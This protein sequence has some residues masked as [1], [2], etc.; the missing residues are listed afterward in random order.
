MRR[1]WDI[2]GKI[3][4][5]I[6]HADLPR[7]I[8]EL[9]EAGISVYAL[10]SI[11]ELTAR[12]TVSRDSW[13]LLR[14]IAEKR[15]AEV[16]ILRRQGLYWRL[17][18]ILRRP[19]LL[20]GIAVIVLLSGLLPSR[21]L[22]VE[23][24]GN[25]D[26]P[27]NQI[28]EAAETVGIC[29]GASRREIRSEQVK[30]RLLEL[31]PQ[32][33]WVGVNTSGCRA[34]ISVSE[35]AQEETAEADLNPSS[36]VA[37]RDGLIRSVTVTS[38]NALC[39]VGQAVKKGEVLVSAY[40]DCGIVIKAA[41]AR[42]EIFAETLRRIETVIP[43]FSE[44][45][46]EVTEVIKNYSLRIGKK[47]IKFYKDSG[48]Y[49]SSCDKMYKEYY[50][51]LPGGFTL[52]VVWVVEQCSI[53]DSSTVS[54]AGSALTDRAESCSEA[55]LLQQMIAGR[56]LSSQTELEQDDALCRLTGQYRCLEMI[57]RAQNEEISSDY[58]EID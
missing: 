2:K 3:T 44:K 17:Q 24:R 56:I 10:D 55:Y 53:R 5:Q 39:A 38:G 23:V 21:I 1:S 36:I 9:M 20:L 52:P 43:V 6:F 47:Q 28:L 49:G 57:G 45:K 50:M 11:D 32:L 41:D 14:G 37:A 33:Q 46:G 7:L 15:N 4:L 35:R 29:F 40:T 34:I 27:K 16:K 48:I 19:A 42:G 25:S 8:E 22:F 31:L 54:A 26:I 13:S 58:G 30:N 18:A 12:L 51:T